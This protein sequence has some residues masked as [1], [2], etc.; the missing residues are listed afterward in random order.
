MSTGSRGAARALRTAARQESNPTASTARSV[1]PSEGPGQAAAGGGDLRR[2]GEQARD[3]AQ[4]QTPS[5][6]RK[7]RSR[8]SPARRGGGGGSRR[9]A[10][11]RAR[12]GARSRCAAAPR[13]DRACRAAGRGRRAPG[14][15]TGRCPRPRGRRPVRSAVV[16]DVETVAARALPPA[17]GRFARLAPAARSDEEEGAAGAAREVAQERLSAE[18]STSPWKQAALE[19]PHQAQPQR[20]AGAVVEGQLARPGRGEGS[21]APSWRPRPPGPRPARGPGRA[22]S[23][24]LSFAS[25]DDPAVFWKRKPASLA[26]GGLTARRAAAAG[27]AG[28]G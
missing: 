17:P 8:P 23:R 2:H 6:S 3:R 25:F 16:G 15:S 12:R 11:S 27:W 7:V 19:Q 24:D 14:R 22:R 26:R 21:T 1:R 5:T 9:R 28:R 4:G 10:G 18:I 20:R 13:P